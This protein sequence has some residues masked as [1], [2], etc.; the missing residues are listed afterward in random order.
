VHALDESMAIE[1]SLGLLEERVADL[2][3]VELVS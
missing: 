1:E 3:G 2:F